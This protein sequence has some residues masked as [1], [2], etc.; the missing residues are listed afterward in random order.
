MDAD[1]GFSVGGITLE[2]V[3]RGAGPPLLLLHGFEPVD[4]RAPFLDLLGRHAQVIAPS[5]PGF[6]HSPRPADFDTIYDL[7]RLYLDVLER[8]P[9]DTVTLLGLSFGGWLA[10]EIAATCP[11]RLERLVLV[12]AVGIKVGDRETRDIL[13]VFNTAPHEVHRRSWHE[14]EK[15]A[16]DFDV[17]SDEALAVHARNRDALC[18]YAW[19]PCLYNSQLRR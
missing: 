10:A 2:V 11:H 16:P 3:R 5:H 9:G 1:E 4:P 18:L 17:M 19:H 6:G 15:W 12:D 14:P 8:L 7:V 13:D